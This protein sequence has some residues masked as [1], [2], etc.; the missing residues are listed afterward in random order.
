MPRESVSLEEFAAYV[1]N[2][3]DQHDGR[4][5]RHPFS[6]NLAIAALGLAGEA[7]EVTDHF[8]KIIRDYGADPSAY[9]V[10]KREELKLE[11][12]DQFHYFIRLMTWAGFT[13][14]EIM[15]ANMDKLDARFGRSSKP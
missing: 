2:N 13:L 3:F 1:V 11:F 5:S 10:H 12:G 6:E 4:A 9:P 7:G 8:K 15:A 14:P